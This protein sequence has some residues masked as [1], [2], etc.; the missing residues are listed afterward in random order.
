MV[1]FAMLRMFQR[2]E[3]VL[4]LTNW[5][6]NGGG[7]CFKGKREKQFFAQT[8]ISKKQRK[9]ESGG[10]REKER[11][12]DEEEERS[13]KPGGSDLKTPVSF[14]GRDNDDTRSRQWKLRF[15]RFVVKSEAWGRRRRRRWWWG[16]RKVVM[17]I[18][19]LPT[20]KLCF[21]MIIN[22]RGSTNSGPVTM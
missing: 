2:R 15:G 1:R 18:V 22:P 5:T 21:L 8:L 6:S 19:L 14:A 10:G 7:K 4:V 16:G 17:F 9:R 20:M 11:V 3:W 13:Q 12:C